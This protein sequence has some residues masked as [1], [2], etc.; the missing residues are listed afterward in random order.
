[1]NKIYVGNLPFSVDEQELHQMFEQ[2]GEIESANL[3]IDRASGRSKGF[4]F[5]AFK[6]KGAMSKALSLNDTEINGRK[7]RV[8]EARERE[9]GGG[10]GGRGGDRRGSGRGDRDRY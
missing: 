5:V 2:F 9:A 6:D 10:G 1:M 8:N 3:I 4:G 7:L